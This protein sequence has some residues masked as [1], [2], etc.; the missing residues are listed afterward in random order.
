MGIFE[1]F[2]NI[3]HPTKKNGWIETDAFFTGKYEK[4]ASGKPG[5]Y[6]LADYNEYQIRFS[7]PK[8]V[9]DG[10]YVFYPLPD[11]DP[12]K[13]KNTH[14]RIRYKKNR[15]WEFEAIGEKD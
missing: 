15:P 13:I 4:A 12:E 6:V 1:I 9:R 5:H 8:G 10:W 2:L 14:I 3:T 11:P 7:T